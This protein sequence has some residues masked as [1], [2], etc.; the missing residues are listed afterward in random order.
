MPKTIEDTFIF[1]IIPDYKK[2]I[3]HFITK[4]ERVNTRGQE[5]E[6]VLFDVKRRRVSDG[7]TKILQSPNVIIGIDETPLPKAFKAFVAK[8]LQD[9]SKRKVFIDGT[10]FLKL[11][12]G[13]YQCKDNELNW[14]I[15]YTING[16]T[17]YIYAM[18]PQKLLLDSTV[19]STGGTC[20]S[21]LFT[22]IIDRMYKVTSVPIIRNKIDYLAAMYYQINLLGKDPESESSLRNIRNMAAKI[23]NISDRDSRTVDI[24]LESGDFTDINTFAQCL[25]RIFQFKEL[26]AA[27]IIAKWMES[28]QPGTQFALE[29]FPSF[30]AMLTN[31]YV[32]GYLNNQ[33]LIEKV[34]DRPLVEYCKNILKIGDSVA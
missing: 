34:T 9:D 16:T 20:F 24:S 30:S 21:R 3:L 19:I 14:L 15:S 5:F 8:D 22:Y 29:F 13:R 12:G 33:N 4:A 18:L 27:A 26:S 7:L 25:T 1:K 32:G 11:V 17:Y 28:F 6:D 10:E 23:S 31:A 2:A